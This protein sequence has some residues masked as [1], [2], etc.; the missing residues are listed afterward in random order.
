MIKYLHVKLQ[1]NILKSMSTGENARK[2]KF[3]FFAN[4]NQ[5]F[6]SRSCRRFKYLLDGN[7]L[8]VLLCIWYR[9]SLEKAYKSTIIERLFIYVKNFSGFSVVILVLFKYFAGII[10]WLVLFGAIVM[11]ICGTIILWYVIRC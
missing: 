11:S 2:S 10:V 4:W 7:I 1:Q 3:V 8:H 6:F 9:L 5:Q